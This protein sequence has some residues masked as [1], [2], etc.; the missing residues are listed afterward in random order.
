MLVVVMGSTAT[1]VRC[2]WCATARTDLEP[3]LLAVVIG[4]S[5]EWTLA[6]VGRVGAR[7]AE[8]D[9]GGRRSPGEYVASVVNIEHAT[10]HYGRAVRAVVTGDGNGP[11]AVGGMV[12]TDLYSNNQFEEL[13]AK[14]ASRPRATVDKKLDP[15]SR[16]RLEFPCSRSDRTA[17]TTHKRLVRLVESALAMGQPYVL[18]PER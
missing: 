13:G 12:V 5:G 16:E 10:G 4:R 2:A 15:S 11:M 6:R 3:A 9:R 7:R 1:E 17:Q 18:I 8:H 14:F